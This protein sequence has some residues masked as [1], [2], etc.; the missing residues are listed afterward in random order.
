M[1]DVNRLQN[2]CDYMRLH[3]KSRNRGTMWEVANGGEGKGAV[4]G[5]SKRRISG[6]VG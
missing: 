3:I 1:R 4:V 6:T 5:L 2:K